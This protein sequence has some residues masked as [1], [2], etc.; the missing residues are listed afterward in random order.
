M[1]TNAT[2]PKLQFLDANGAP[3]VGGKLYTYAAGTTTPLATYTDYGGGT[4]NAN[5]VIL[6]SRG[7]ASVWLGTALYKMALYSATDVLIWTVDNIGGF[8]TLAQ[9]AASGGSNLVGFLQAGT[10]AVATT[11]QTKLRESVSVLDFGADPT[12]VADSTTAINA[13]AL[14]VSSAGGLVFFPPGTYKTT[15]AIN[16][17]SKVTYYGAGSASVIAC[18]SGDV[19]QFYGTGLSECTVR[20]LKISATAVGT[21][22]YVG[23][24]NF[25]TSTNCY[26]SNVE[27]V[28][29]AWAGILL[30]NSSYCKISGVYAHGW[31]GSVQDSADINV[32][33]ISQFNI[34]DGNFLYGGGWHGVLVQD[35]GTSLIPSKNIITN[36]RIGAHAAY[37][38]VTYN[39]DSAD[40]FTEI[41]NNFIEGI[42]GSVLTGSSGAGIYVQSS[43]GAIVS[44]NTIRN[45]CINTTN[46]TL[47]PA[48]IG[49]NNI[50]S[51]LSP[52][53]CTGNNI[54]DIVNYN[55]IEVAS[56]VGGVLIV[57]NTIRLVNN[58]SSSTNGVYINAASNCVVS[59]NVI[60]LATA[61]N[62]SGISLYANG[63]STS[64]TVISG[65]NIT[66]GGYTG[67]RTIQT[68]A[69][70][71]NFVTV[72][73]NTAT[74]GSAS[75]ISYRLAY[76]NDGS[77]TGNVGN[78]TTT[79][80]LAI[81]TCLRLL[82]AGNNVTTTGTLSVTTSGTCTGS[83]YDK[84]NY[85]G[86][87]YSFLQNAATGLIA[88]IF[89]N[90]APAASNWAV[91]D[92]TEQS[93]P[94]VGQPKGWR[95]TVAG[96]PGT[97]VSEGNL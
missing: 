22:A 33:R 26:V 7:E 53:V 17:Y 70:V 30:S 37:G 68:A 6:D 2:P 35:P 67:I 69:Y 23:A 78:A 58:T 19:N 82:L 36:N 28:G 93:V 16:L 71:N 38:I 86:T 42:L 88:E 14:A 32:F 5:P 12:G 18:T 11:V 55:G 75:C 92:R 3:L 10:G 29:M 15:A 34:V 72:S 13:A 9:L 97:W 54:I 96:I 60:V 4:A 57:G 43:G 73:N 39:I 41:T 74:G 91:G 31:Q 63:V 84:T 46:A 90:A 59:N 64:N 56:S 27:I 48:G 1:T 21:T 40:S 95:C 20:D 76:I 50:S 79:N 89:G 77:I 47:T 61:T 81:S 49:F 94:V 87:S 8:A 85:H 51:G 52:C 80:T 45:C 25:E 65:N 24:I 62:T 66:G 44:G 83:Y